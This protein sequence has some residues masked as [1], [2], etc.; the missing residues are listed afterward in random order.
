LRIFE[1]HK[2]LG[3]ARSS[4]F[5]GSKTDVQLSRNVLMVGSVALLSQPLSKYQKISTKISR[6]FLFMNLISFWGLAA[7]SN[8]SW[9]ELPDDDDSENNG[10]RNQ[11]QC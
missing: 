10:N 3:E 4:L 2:P 8:S 7:F 9:G 1:Q 11:A 6:M 5:V